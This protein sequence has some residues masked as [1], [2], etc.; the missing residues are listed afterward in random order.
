LVASSRWLPGI[1]LEPLRAAI[2]GRTRVEAL[3][4]GC[5]IIADE[6]VVGI[7]NETRIARAIE[8]ASARQAA[9]KPAGRRR[10]TLMEEVR[11]VAAAMAN[12]NHHRKKNGSSQ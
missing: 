2:A 10:E 8:I 1:D 7:T 3:A 5:Q 9:Y 6:N 11:R 4:K 12:E